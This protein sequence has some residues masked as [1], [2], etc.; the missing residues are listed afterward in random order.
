MGK[1]RVFNFISLNGYFEGK[2][3]DISWH[4]HG[5]EEN[6]FAA[7][8]LSHQSILLFGRITYEL[9]A[10]FWPTDYAIKNDPLVA[11][12]MNKAEKIVFSRT[13]EKVEWHNTRLMKENIV[14]EIKRMK[15]LSERDMTILGSGSIVTQFAENGLIDEYQL[16]V[17]PVILG[18]G[19]T[20]FNGIKNR[21]SLKLTETRTFKSGV[22][23]LNYEKVD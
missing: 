9:M 12:G 17:D 20:I 21:L 1:I 10:G 15:Q 6:K 7:Q 2:G 13:L 19:T 14:L 16:M 4:V 3:R 8:S 22:I 18:E 23:L 5:E 11:E